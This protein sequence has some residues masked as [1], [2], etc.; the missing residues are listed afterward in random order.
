MSAPLFATGLTT[1][2]SERLQAAVSR[3]VGREVS[4]TELVTDTLIE[5]VER[6]GDRLLA[7]EGLKARQG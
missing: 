5:A 7:L 1:E 2:E 6:I 3:V 4:D